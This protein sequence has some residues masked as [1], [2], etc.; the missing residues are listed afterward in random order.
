M[1]FL[2]TIYE[3]KKIN[4]IITNV[5]YGKKKFL[6]NLYYLNEIYVSLSYFC[7]RVN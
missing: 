1:R 3:Y 5:R 4:Q 2:G 7:D 6:D